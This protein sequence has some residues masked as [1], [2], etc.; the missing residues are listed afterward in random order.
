MKPTNASAILGLLML[1]VFVSPH[2]IAQDTGWYGGLNLG[3]AKANFDDGRIASGL[4]GAGVAT[5]A[6]TERDSSN[7]LKLY[8]GYQF[9]R[10]FA[11]EAGYFNLGKFG[12]TATTVPP[13]VLDGSIRLRGVNVDLVGIAPLTDKFSVFGRVGVAHAQTRDSFA[14]S[15]AAIAA[16]SNASKRDTNLKVGVGMEYKFT[17]MMGVRGEFERYRINDAM[18]SRGNVDMLSVGLVVRFGAKTPAP[19]PQ[20]YNAPYVAPVAAP[21]PPPAPAPIVMAP[22]PPPPPAPVYQAPPPLPPPPPAPAPVKVS[23]S[24]DSL[25]DF[26]KSTVKAEGRTALDKFVAD[27]RGSSYDMIDVIGHTDRLGSTDYNL[28]LSARRADAVK[29]Y[30]VQTSGLQAAKVATRGAG[31]AQP[32]TRIEDCKGNRQTPQL[33]TCLQPDRRVELHVTATRQ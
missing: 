8:G 2:A 25:F 32:V 31:E 21:V 24:A 6:V 23:L 15:G 9:N 30:L 16:T 4:L 29:E 19:A 33:I 17:P 20:V 26:D 5:T 12:F 22:P 28:K 11:V 13:G 18:G 14:G 10:N 1:G 27:L 3:R 7:G